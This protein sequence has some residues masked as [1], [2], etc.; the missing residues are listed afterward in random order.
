MSEVADRYDRLA[1]GFAAKVASVPAGRWENPSPCAGWTARDVVRH[2]IDGHGIFLGQVGRDLGSIPSVD[3]DPVAAFDATRRIVLADLEDP[4]RAKEEYDGFFGRTS[5]EAAI[6]RFMAFDLL[7]HGWDLARA[8]GLD[9]RLDPAEVKLQ[10]EQ[11]PSFGEPLR[12]SGACGPELQAPAGADEQTR[13]LAFL[14][15]R[16]WD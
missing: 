13:L 5:F 11:A 2:V 6:D 15:R 14:G 3:D 8:A 10:I 16:A 12:S 1:G 9:D 7:V 4:A